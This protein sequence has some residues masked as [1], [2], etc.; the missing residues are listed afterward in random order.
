VLIEPQSSGHANELMESAQRR[1][2]ELSDHIAEQREQAL[3]EHI[4]SVLVLRDH[5]IEAVS[6]C[7]AAN[8]IINLPTG[9]GKTLVAVRVMDYF[10]QLHPGKNV[11]FVVPTTALVRQQARYLRRH[12]D[13]EGCT[14]AEL[15]GRQMDAW[16]LNKWQQCKRGNKVLL[17]TPEVFRSSLVDSRY[18]QVADMSL[19]VFD[20]CHHANGNSPMACMLR[21][22][23]N[24]QQVAV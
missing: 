5:Q 1:E 19:C 17:G 4:Q 9:T 8:H 10:L 7:L 12:S 3:R 11:V 15:C 14:V 22:A 2:S 13:V 16:D 24:S 21:D 20:E 18:L 23:L 6:K